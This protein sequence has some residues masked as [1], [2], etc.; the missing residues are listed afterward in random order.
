MKCKIL[1]PKFTVLEK[2]LWA[3]SVIGVTALFFLV[4]ERNPLTLIATLFGVSGLIFTAKGN[5]IGKFLSVIFAVFYAVVSLSFRYYGEA[6]TYLF[7]SLPTDL[8]SAVV[9]LKNPSKSGKSEVRMTH[10]NPKKSGLATLITL[11]M[12]IVFYFVLRSLNTANL[13]ISTLSV[14]TSM[15]AAVFTVMRVP[16]YAI[17]YA[18][19]DIVLIAMWILASIKN[20]A[21]IPM[22]FNFTIFLINDMYGFFNWK[23]LRYIQDLKEANVV[24]TA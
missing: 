6:M 23:K 7:M 11:I 8:F 20:P 12:T 17:G 19:N 5:V 4:P 24:K 21:Y 3:F 18:A 15:I 22:I 13:G 2:C 10:L 1:F 9:W 16:Y 14:T